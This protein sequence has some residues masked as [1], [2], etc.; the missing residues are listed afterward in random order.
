MCLLIHFFLTLLKLIIAFHKITL[1][2]WMM[3][4]KVSLLYS[5]YDRIC[6]I[7]PPK[8]GCDILKMRRDLVVLMIAF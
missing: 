5:T 6:S 8:I 7:D 2:M 1:Y 4:P 3:K